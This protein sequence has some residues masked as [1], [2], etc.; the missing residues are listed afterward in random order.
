MNKFRVTLETELG[1]DE[2][3]SALSLFE[4]IELI[5]IEKRE[6]IKDIRS[7]GEVNHENYRIDA[8]L[9]EELKKRLRDF[10]V[11]YSQV[12]SGD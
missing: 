4:D 10:T 2:L 9:L 7:V 5:E 1:V 6:I 12:S 3:R 11:E 8:A